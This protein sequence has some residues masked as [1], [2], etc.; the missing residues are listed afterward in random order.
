MT[1]SRL[2]DGDTHVDLDSTCALVVATGQQDENRVNG[3]RAAHAGHRR[4]K[5]LARGLGVEM[6]TAR[7]WRVLQT[8]QDKLALLTRTCT[9]VVVLLGKPNSTGAQ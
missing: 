3:A 1:Q 8:V 6:V 5:T 2:G 4:W 9:N 7:T